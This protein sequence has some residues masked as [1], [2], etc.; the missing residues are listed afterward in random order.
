VTLVHRPRLERLEHVPRLEEEGG[1]GRGGEPS[2]RRCHDDRVRAP[3]PAAVL[4]GTAAWCAPALAP[5]LPPVAGA[6]GIPRR[7]DGPR[8][9]V[10][11]T[12]DD[13]PHPMGTPA[14]LETL[15]RAEAFATF[16][17]VGEQVERWPALAARI[18]AEGHAVGVHGHRHRN[19]LRLTPRALD[20]DLERAVHVIAA[21]CGRRPTLYRPPYGIFSPAGLALVRRRGWTPLLW[22]RWGRDWRRSATPASIAADVTAGLGTGDVLLLH[23]ADHYSAP[24][25]WRRTSAAL[26][27]ILAEI[28]RRGLRTE[29]V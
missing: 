20:A 5:S 3:V 23:D 19:L 4:A 6:L 7:L 14:V 22:S 2:E 26:P 27:E 11:V 18:A 16:F 9:A 13:G 15:A 1:P 12:F 24:G 10:A 25:S 21:A 17:L 29:T 8:A 28:S